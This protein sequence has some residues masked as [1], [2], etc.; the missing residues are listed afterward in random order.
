MSRKRRC[1]SRSAVQYVR[2]HRQTP[3]LIRKVHE[4]DSVRQRPP[5]S[6]NE[7]DRQG[8]RNPLSVE[9]R[10]LYVHTSTGVHLFTAQQAPAGPRLCTRAFLGRSNKWTTRSRAGTGS[11]LGR[12]ARAIGQRVQSG[13]TSRAHEASCCRQVEDGRLERPATLRRGARIL[14]RG[15]GWVTRRG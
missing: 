11:A 15:R 8:I 1:K 9:R 2:V 3:E 14:G 7:H 13:R 10:S 12:Q 6:E 5:T 4:F